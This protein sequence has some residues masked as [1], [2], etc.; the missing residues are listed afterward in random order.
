MISWIMRI[1]FPQMMTKT[2]LIKYNILPDISCLD[3]I[4]QTTDIKLD[5]WE[6]IN[7]YSYTF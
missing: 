5:V 3:E 4:P 2:I 1:F 7:G 6:K